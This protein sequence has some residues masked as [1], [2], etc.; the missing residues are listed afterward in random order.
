M[1]RVFVIWVSNLGK[2]HKF[3]QIW[4][5]QTYYSD[6]LWLFVTLQTSFV[7]HDTTTAAAV[8]LRQLCIVLRVWQFSARQTLHEF[9]Q[10]ESAATRRSLRAY[11]GLGV[12]DV[13]AAVAITA[14][15]W[16]RHNFHDYVPINW[17]QVTS[18]SMSK[19]KIV[20]YNNLLLSTCYNDIELY[21]MYDPIPSC[22]KKCAMNEYNSIRMHFNV[23]FDLTLVSVD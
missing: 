6:V 9:V 8:V 15:S 7:N 4:A 12:A 16:T 22:D 2:N 23:I 19:S 18:G 13:L 14:V 3:M 21:P 5:L 10:A 17:N 11:R 20:C 1:K